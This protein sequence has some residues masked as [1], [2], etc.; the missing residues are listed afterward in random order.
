MNNVSLLLSLTF[1]TSSLQ[2]VTKSYVGSCTKFAGLF[3]TRAS[4]AIE[5]RGKFF[6]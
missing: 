4:N 3:L 5:G 1:Y 6:Y 2:I